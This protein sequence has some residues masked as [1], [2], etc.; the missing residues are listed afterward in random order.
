MSAASFAIDSIASRAQQVS[1]GALN[2]TAVPSPCVSVCKMN[3]AQSYCTGCLRT[4]QEIGA[5]SRLDEPGKRA[6]WAVIW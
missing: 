6:I 2:G 3:E 1:A 4:L 5:W